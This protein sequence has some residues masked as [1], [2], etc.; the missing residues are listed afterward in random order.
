MIFTKLVYLIP[1][2]I[3]YYSPISKTMMTNFDLER[4][5]RRLNL[6]LVGIFNKDTLPMIRRDGYYIINLQDDYH[7]NG[8]DLMGTH[9]TVFGVQKNKAAYFDS[10]GFPPPIQVEN[11]LKPYSPFPYSSRQIQSMQSGVCGKYVIYWIYY[12]HTRNGLSNP[13]RSM[14]QFLSLWSPEPRKNREILLKRYP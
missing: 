5:C 12:M 6:P 7:S 9:W 3:N 10:F 14:A 8:Q 4:E 13:R 11:F 2:F 1:A